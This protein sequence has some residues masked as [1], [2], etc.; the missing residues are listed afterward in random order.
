M[1][2][3]DI[4]CPKCGK[5]LKVPDRSLLGRKA[6][7][8]KCQASFVLVE[9]EV[10]QAPPPRAETAPRAK[11]APRPEPAARPESD[12]VPVERKLPEAGLAA[13]E[14]S[15][16]PAPVPDASPVSPPAPAVEST[17]SAGFDGWNL[18]PELFMTTR[19]ARRR[20]SSGGR[21]G[22][23][24]AAVLLL[25]AAGAGGYYWSQRPAAGDAVAT[26][27]QRS[28]RGAGNAEAGSNSPSANE[29]VA[30]PTSGQPLLLK[31]VPEG[32]Q[33]L[34]H[35][36]PAELW[37]P[38]GAGEELRAC[39]G[40]LGLWLEAQIKSRCLLPP[41]QIEEVLFALIPISREEFDVAVV[42]RS[43]E[44][45]RKSELIEKINGELVDLPRPHYRGKTTA[46]LI[47]DSRTFAIAPASM[48][49]SLVESAET[50]SVTSE[51]IQALLA[52]TDRSRHF[53][54]VAELED[55]RTGASTL[56][57]AAAQNLLAAV[58]D[59]LGDDA[60]TAAWSLHLGNPDEDRELFSELLVRNRS[61]RSTATLQRDLQAK[62]TA[63]PPDVLNLVYQTHPGRLGEKKVVGR[64]PV[65]TKVVEQ[66]ALIDREKRFVRVRWSLPE[67]AAPNL[68]LGAYLTWRQTTLADFGKHAPAAPSRAQELPAT[69]A[70]RLQKVVDVEF[71]EKDSLSYCIN[72]VAD[73]IGVKISL[74]GPGMKRVGAT[75]NQPSKF[76]MK[77]A[78]ASS[79]LHR[80]LVP[81]RLVLIVDEKSKT[82][83][84]T[85]DE[86]AEDKKLKP[87]PLTPPPP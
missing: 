28:G 42:V 64:F 19:A 21:T 52:H 77:G 57:P 53:T 68:A 84:V 3:L 43:L 63:V 71:G 36:R 13:L 75:Q 24:A 72:Y 4:P 39:L 45:V 34:V 27:G 29:P 1:P 18:E 50:A 31:L 44:P 16:A 38:G 66:S 7:C 62:L 2:A 78:T 73:E 6:R 25:A 69:V 23:I 35:L 46:A 51:G 80:M 65:M 26:D 41:E 37:I 74:D 70:E 85:S 33:I 8:G 60:E 82:A 58:L 12:L 11:A 47:Q 10:Q 20:R 87:F 56:A 17:P 5:R 76:T 22:L 83:R 9:P 48:A 49:E 40:P 59:F 30:S 14:L 15:Q 79:V 32:A 55:V 67:R 81:I 54:I 86:E 61:N